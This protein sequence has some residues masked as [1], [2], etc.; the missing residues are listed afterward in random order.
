[1]DSMR[2]TLDLPEGLVDEARRLLGFKFKTDTVIA[3]LQ[4]LI[5]R[6]RMSE[7]K[8]LAGKV[9]IDFNPDR[10][11]RRPRPKQSA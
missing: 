6:K 1:M 11:R 9:Q 3:A 4:E 2:T 7:L 10:T 5:R 8:S